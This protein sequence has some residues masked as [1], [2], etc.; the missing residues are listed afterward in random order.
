M[1]LKNFHIS[2]GTLLAEEETFYASGSSIAYGDDL[3]AACWMRHG[4]D[5]NESIGRLLLSL[6]EATRASITSEYGSLTNPE[7]YEDIRVVEMYGIDEL[8]ADDEHAFLQAV[9]VH[10]GISPSNGLRKIRAA[11]PPRSFRIGF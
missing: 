2:A 11:I 9:K 5:E 6:S 3:L 8:E 10:G 1:T 7:L 4:D